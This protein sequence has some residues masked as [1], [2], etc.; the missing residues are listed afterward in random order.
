MR[1]L[2]R[3]VAP[4][5]CAHALAEWHDQPRTGCLEG[6]QSPFACHCRGNG[7]ALAA[8]SAGFGACTLVSRESPPVLPTHQESHD[9]RSGT[10][11]ACR[12]VE[13]RDRRC[14]DRGRRTE[15][16]LTATRKTETNFTGTRSVQADLGGRTGVDLAS[17][18]KNGPV[19]PSPVRRMRNSG[20]AEIATACELERAGRLRCAFQ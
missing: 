2:I 17:H 19:L 12:S 20:A 5:S 14:R 4:Q 15:G 1:L 16:R 18:A 6:G 8:A 3:I 13:V 7:L 10:Q 11:T 9:R